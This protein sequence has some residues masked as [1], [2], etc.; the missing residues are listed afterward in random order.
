LVPFSVFDVALM[1]RMP[2]TGE[3]VNFDEEHVTTKIRDLVRERVHE[4]EQ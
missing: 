3:P 1:T 2:A 4:L